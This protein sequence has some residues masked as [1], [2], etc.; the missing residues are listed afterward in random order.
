MAEELETALAE[1]L[2][3]RAVQ[4]FGKIATAY[5]RA[6]AALRR[7][8]ADPCGTNDRPGFVN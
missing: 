6:R 1:G 5:R 4:S 2:P 7:K 3:L 8:P